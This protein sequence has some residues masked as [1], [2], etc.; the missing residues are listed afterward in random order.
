M[1]TDPPA[2]THPHLPNPPTPTPA[3]SSYLDKRG[4]QATKLVIYKVLRNY[5]RFS[6]RMIT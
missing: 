5:P 1:I 6:T 3:P 4:N 2:P